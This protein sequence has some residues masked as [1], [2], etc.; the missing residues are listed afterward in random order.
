MHLHRQRAASFVVGAAAGGVAAALLAR[1][2]FERA[3]R[4]NKGLLTEI[5][6]LL[7][8]VDR[9]RHEADEL[10]VQAEREREGN[11]RLAAELS[12]AQ[13]RIAEL[14]R[15]EADLRQGLGRLSNPQPE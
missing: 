11:A 1:A 12:E 6:G 5:E 15:L 8:E 4:A 9:R 2:R 3:L 7:T 13:S 10:G 14:G